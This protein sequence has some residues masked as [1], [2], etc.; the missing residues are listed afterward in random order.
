MNVTLRRG[1]LTLRIPAHIEKRPQPKSTEKVKRL[2]QKWKMQGLCRECGRGRGK[3]KW[4][5]RLGHRCRRCQDSENARWGRKMAQRKAAS[6]S[7][8]Q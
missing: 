6:T 2:K 4:G 5:G 8:V 7:N 1:I 3:S